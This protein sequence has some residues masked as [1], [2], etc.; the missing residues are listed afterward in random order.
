MEALKTHKVAQEKILVFNLDAKYYRLVAMGEEKVEN[1][2]L[3]MNDLVYIADNPTLFVKILN[4][5]HYPPIP[6]HSR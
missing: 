4:S 6:R 2:S 1:V 5:C 3:L